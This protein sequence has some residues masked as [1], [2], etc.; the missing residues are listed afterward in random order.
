MP[1]LTEKYSKIGR[2][3]MN[4]HYLVSMLEGFEVVSYR[5]DPDGLVMV[6][7]ENPKES[8]AFLSMWRLDLDTLTDEDGYT[9]VFGYLNQLNYAN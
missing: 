2:C 4:K 9:V 5:E 3:Q 7:F 1:S 6:L 8:K